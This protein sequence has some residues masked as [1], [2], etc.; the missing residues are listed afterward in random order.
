VIVG[1]GPDKILGTADDVVMPLANMTRTIVIADVQGESGLRQI[2]I[3]L[4]YTVGAKTRHFTL[5]SYIAQ[6]S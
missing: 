2:T 3:T 5:V 4:D 6:F 1:P